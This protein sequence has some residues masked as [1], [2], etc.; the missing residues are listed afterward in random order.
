MFL[1]GRPETPIG[2]AQVLLV[3]LPFQNERGGGVRSTLLLLTDWVSF[4]WQRRHSSMLSA[5][6]PT[7]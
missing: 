5:N 7:M 6:N 1:R 3:A 4:P 2:S